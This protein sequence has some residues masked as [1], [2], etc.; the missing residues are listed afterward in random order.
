MASIFW[1]EGSQQWLMRYDRGNGEMGIKPLSYEQERSRARERSQEQ[2]KASATD[3]L[4]SPGM[5]QEIME[6]IRSGNAWKSLP[7]YFN[8]NSAQWTPSNQNASGGTGLF[9]ANYRRSQAPLPTDDPRE[10]NGS[11][12]TLPPPPMINPRSRVPYE[13]ENRND[14]I[15]P[16]P[17][18]YETQINITG[19]A[20]ARYPEP[21]PPPE[22][23]VEESRELPYPP[24][25]AG[26]PPPEP[27]PTMIVDY[28]YGPEPYLPTELPPMAVDYDYGRDPRKIVD[29]RRRVPPPFR[30]VSG[31]R[32]DPRRVVDP[33]QRV[34]GS[35]MLGSRS[36]LM[37]DAINRGL[38]GKLGFRRFRN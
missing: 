18:Q 16:V 13:R 28:G 38:L 7:G 2:T 17:R 10:L 19:S 3:L 11:I 23:L 14:A 27:P 35:G 29:P 5:M 22:V 26:Y 21:A 12:G 34:Q 1:D 9:Q 37:R 20:P 36:E 4:N 15:P 31:Y 30:M 24:S 32:E 25:E 8:P 33:R 6:K